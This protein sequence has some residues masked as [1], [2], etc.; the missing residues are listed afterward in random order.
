MKKILIL[1]VS[2]FCCTYALPAYSQ[3]PS[4]QELEKRFWPEDEPETPR[5]A[6]EKPANIN[7]LFIKT[8]ILVGFVCAIIIGG[9]WLFRR[10]SGGKFNSFSKEGSIVLLERKFLSP[11]TSVWFLEV[12]NQPFIVVESVHGVAI[13]KVEKSTHE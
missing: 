2:L 4:D 13:N 11:K 1:F 5:K 8:I 3:P 12:K 7:R 9:G 6:D 10:L